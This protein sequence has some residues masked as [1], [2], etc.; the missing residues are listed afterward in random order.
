[1][2]TTYGLRRNSK[3]NCLQYFHVTHGLPPD[4]GHD[5]F[6][7]VCPDILGK[8]LT[9]F[10]DEQI[11]SLKKI[12]DIISSFPYMASDKSNRPSALLWSS[13]RLIVKQKAAQMWCL[14]R[15]IFIMVGNVIPIGN[16][17]WQLLLHLREICDIAASPAHSVDTITYLEGTVFDFLELYIALIPHE[18]LT[19]KMHYLQHYSKQIQKFG[20]LSS[21]W[22]LRYE[23]KHSVFKNVRSTQN[24]KNIAYTL[25]MRHQLK[26]AI[27][28]ASEEI[29]AEEVTYSGGHILKISD[30]PSHQQSI[31]KCEIGD[32]SEVYCVKAIHSEQRHFFIGCCLVTN[33]MNNLCQFSVL[34]VIF[35]HNMLHYFVVEK[36]HTLSFENHYHAYLVQKHDC[37][38]N[39]YQIVIEIVKTSQLV[40]SYPLPLYN[41]QLPSREDLFVVMKYK[42][43]QELGQ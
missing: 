38:E 11:I 22:T 35:I 4:L 18:K 3:L 25:T 31:I 7:G 39:Q 30:M 36:L 23:A 19:P 28:F 17:Y 8:V 20:P 43:P 24:M 16:D 21:C 15:L 14:I 33:I 29:I 34:K 41:L 37:M 26:Q 12:N 27:A 32:V 2:K 40:D 1:M 10:I 13:G 42:L 6:E 5:L 9:H